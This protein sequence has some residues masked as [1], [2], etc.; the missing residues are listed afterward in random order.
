M[1]FYR[2]LFNKPLP[3]FSADS[4]NVFSLDEVFVFVLFV[5]VFVCLFVFCFCFLFFVNS[6]I[7]RVSQRPL[8]CVFIEV[9]FE[10]QKMLEMLIFLPMYIKVKG[11]GCSHYQHFS[12]VEIF[13]FFEKVGG[14]GRCYTCP[15]PLFDLV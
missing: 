11:L 12:G 5:F 6:I 1:Q 13:N 10:K 8:C 2:E 3:N 7:P 15:M 4:A 14:G 9:D